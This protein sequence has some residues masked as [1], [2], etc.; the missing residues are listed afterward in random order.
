[1]ALT[2]E[3]SDTQ[4][5]LFVESDALVGLAQSVLSQEGRERASVSIALVDDATIR[6]INRTHLGHD[7]PTDVISFPLSAPE[8]PVL[9]GEIV[10]STEMAVSQARVIGAEPHDELALY[11]VHGLLHLCGYDDA[12]EADADAMRRRE[13]EVLAAAGFPKSSEA[14]AR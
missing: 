2:I 12:S 14:R 5:C 4:G 13:V 7:W 6:G 1:V 10:I 8:D 3:I 11:V 9:C